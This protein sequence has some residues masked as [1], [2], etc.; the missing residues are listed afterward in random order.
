MVAEQQAIE[1]LRR[2]EEVKGKILEY[3]FWMQK[4]GY[5]E[6]TITRRIRFLKTM[7]NRGANLA[8]PESVKEMLARQQNW[9][10]K[11]KE[12]AVETYS[13]FLKMQGLNWNPPKFKSVKKYLSSQQ[14]KRSTA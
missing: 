2:N 6:T 13:L 3:A 14:S 12:I 4:E 11:T 5:A 8:D 10:V 1:V 7:T 9:Q